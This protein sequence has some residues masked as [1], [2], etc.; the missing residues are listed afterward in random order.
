MSIKSKKAKSVTA[1]LGLMAN[2]LYT[3][4]E[5]LIKQP[6]RD[7]KKVMQYDRKRNGEQHNRKR[8]KPTTLHWFIA[9]SPVSTLA[10]ILLGFRELW[11][12]IFKK[13]KYTH[14]LLW[15]MAFSGCL[16]LFGA[17]YSW[18]GFQSRRAISALRS[19]AAIAF[20]QN[21]FEETVDC[22]EQLET[23]V[24]TLSPEEEFRLARSLSKT[25]QVDRAS[26][27]LK[28][29]APGQGAYTGYAPAHQ[30]AAVSLAR[31]L[32]QPYPAEAKQLL[33]WHLDAG[34][35]TESPDVNFARAQ[36]FISIAQVP[37]AIDAMKIAALSKPSLN[38]N[39]ALLHKQAGETDNEQVA[40]LL[41]RSAFESR[42]QDNPADHQA[43]IGLVQTYLRQRNP[44]LAQQQL[45][46][47]VELA[48]EVFR[49]Q[50]SD[51]FMQKYLALADTGNVA[52]KTELLINAWRND[53]QNVATC[54][55]AIQ[56]HRQQ[57]EPDRQFVLTAIEQ[58]A[59][60]H[61]TAALPQFALGIIYHSENRLSESK[62]SIEAAHQNLDPDQPGYAVVAN[63][64]AWLMAHA[65]QPNLEQAFKL[66]DS[67]V[68][69]N[70]NAGGLRDTL[71]TV[72]MKQGLYQQS[73]VEFQKALRT[74]QNKSPVH[75]KIAKIYDQIGQPELA[76]LH[77]NRSQSN[78]SSI[79][80]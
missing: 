43:R 49:P 73:L 41:A 13:K 24:A 76:I 16:L 47:G 35:D 14:A 38:L 53:L 33:K 1:K 52:L 6:T 79:S 72:L 69:K 46:T 70:P 48:P 66:A 63:N 22:Y 78:H 58:V 23:T 11:T 57:A 37:Q 31:T 19:R 20:E 61:P 3:A 10:M 9:V 15:A 28:K 36:Y 42:L 29:L 67:A 34:G 27:L 2:D 7:I 5:L 18:L 74:I 75:L 60:E 80:D 51:F 40:L 12:T 17:G 64:L 44:K 68:R 62:M 4:V 56:L 59:A 77:R 32:K 45:Q 55:A 30:L 65:Q 25:N 39:L 71:A 54:Q 21:K 26:E 50:L 8:S